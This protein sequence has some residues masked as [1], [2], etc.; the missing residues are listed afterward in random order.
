VIAEDDIDKVIKKV[1]D[2]GGKVLG[3]PMQIPGV[4]RYVSFNYSEGIVLHID[5]LP[6]FLYNGFRPFEDL[7]SHPI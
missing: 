5:I 4:W 3:E 7:G 2:A 6:V 1:I